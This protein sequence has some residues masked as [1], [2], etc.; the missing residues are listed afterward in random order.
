METEKQKLDA[1]LN[2]FIGLT[3]RSKVAVIVPMYGYWKD[4]ES[5][6]LNEETLKYSLDRIYSSVHELYLI[7]VAEDRRMSREVM[8]ILAGKKK[9]G[10]FI[11]VPAEA[12]TT[13]A[14]YVRMGMDVALSE[15]NKA[16]YIVIVNPWMICQHNGVDVLVDRANRADD[17]RII[18][19]YDIKGL[20]KGEEFD[21]FTTT[22]P[23]EQ[24]DLNLNFVAMKRYMAEECPL[25]TRYRTHAFLARDLAA[26]VYSRGYE[27]ITSQRIPIFTFDVDFKELE[28]EEN[29]EHDRQIFIEKWKY[30][31]GI[32]Y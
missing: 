12:G 14:E 23:V 20:V 24:R 3:A 16:E 26:S 27:V 19:G 10:N 22:S 13:Y 11:G 29:F 21:V 32:C 5:Q 28:S 25:D 17:A 8:S 31:P 15:A 2:N 9:A 18:A 1:K 30:D 4:T 6:Q 7:V